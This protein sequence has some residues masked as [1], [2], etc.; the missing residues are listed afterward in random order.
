MNKIFETYNY[1]IESEDTQRLKKIII[2]NNL[3]QLSKNIPGDIIE[4]G[5]FKGTGLIFWLKMLKIFDS[6]SLKKVI[7]FDTFGDFPEST[8]EYEKKSVKIF[9]N[10]SNYKSKNN[11]LNIIKQKI[12]KAKVHERCR[13]IKGDIIK[14]S[15]NYVM[16]NKGSRISLLHLDLDTYAGTKCALENFYP[17]VSPGGVIIFDEYGQSGWGESDAVDEF[18]F[19][20][21][22]DIKTVEFSSK[23]TAYLIKKK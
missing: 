14:T 10:Q 12:K 3:F 4:C 21:K 18:F 5:V 7:G 15:K 6:Q 1:L 8:L 9:Q 16:K 13:L 23:P 17:L 2:R 11:N 19:N 20:K 22:C